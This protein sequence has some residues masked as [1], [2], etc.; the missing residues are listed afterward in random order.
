MFAWSRTWYSEQDGVFF[1]FDKKSQ[2]DYTVEVLGFRKV[3]AEE[4]YKHRNVLQV[5][6]GE[7]NEFLELIK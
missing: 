1:N 2:R 5:P 6:W 4:A 7:F 3:S